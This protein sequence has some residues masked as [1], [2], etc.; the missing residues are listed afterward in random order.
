MQSHLQRHHPDLLAV[1]AAE[2]NASGKQAAVNALFN[3]K[4]PFSSPRAV[5]ITKSIATFICKDLRPY[6]V[7][8]NEGFRQMLQTL[9]PRYEIPSRKYFTEKAV[10]AL[11]DETKE[12]REWTVFCQEGR[13]YVRWMEFTSHGVVCDN[14]CPFCWRRVGNAFFSASDKGDAWDPYRMSY[15]KKNMHLWDELKCIQG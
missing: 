7:V 14:N 9:E 8:E 10:P 1:R 15:G 11:Y 6:S 3:T 5:N 12:G 13:A 2:A 4:L